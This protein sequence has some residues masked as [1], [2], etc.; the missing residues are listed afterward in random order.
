MET[1]FP[2]PP[3]LTE[4]VFAALEDKAK[5]PAASMVVLGMLAGVY[6]GLGGLVA[7]VALAGAD[8]LPYG[9][10][11]LIAGVAFSLGLALVLI[12]GAELFTGNTLM[13]GSV[14]TGRLPMPMV[15]RALSIVYITNFLGS[16]VLA[17]A[18]F[19]AGVQEAGNGAVGRAALEL[20]AAKLDKSFTTAFASGILANMLVC[21]AVWMAYAGNSVADRIAALIM[22]IAAF[23]AAG[24][25][26][27]VANMYLLPYA[28][29]VQSVIPE[30]TAS[31][32]LTGIAGNL[33]PTTLGNILGGSLVAV[34]YGY[35]YRKR[36]T[37]MEAG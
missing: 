4:T 28:F 13:A 5:L 31:V 11:Q 16:V 36:K 23:V 26:H 7:T 21:L 8:S 19:L 6:I 34:A 14:A 22:P 1:R 25:E 29:L 27:S 37:L 32:S 3:E 33:L 9:A 24:F 30:A 20:A 10:A 17:A 12:A 2:Q 15:L 35:V 18:A